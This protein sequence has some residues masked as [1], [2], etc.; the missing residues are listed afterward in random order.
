MSLSYRQIIA[1]TSIA[2]FAFA[3]HNDALAQLNAAPQT[4]GPTTGGSPIRLRQPTQDPQSAAS[5]S[6][7]P[8]R[9]AKLGEFETFV[10]LP[11]LGAELVNEYIA[12]TT[13]TSPVVPPDYV[14]QTGDEVLITLWG[15]VDAD[16][17]LIVDRTGRITLPRVG[18]VQVAG[19]RY[20]E[21]PDAISK[22]VSHV[23]KGYQISISMGRLRAV[24]VYISGFAERPGSYMAAGLSTVTS[25]LLRAGGPSAAG[26][27]RNI[28]LKRNGKNVTTIDLYDLLLRGEKSSDATLQPGD[29]I[30]IPPIG[31]QA[32]V[33]GSVNR[34]AVFELK[35]GEKLSDLLGWAGDFSPV[36]D[37][38]RVLLERLDERNGVRVREVNLSEMSGTS[39]A[40]GDIIRALSAVNANL[41][42]TA[43][44]RRIRVEGEVARPGDYLLPPNS[45][46][47]DAIRAAG[48]LT[49]SAYPYGAEFSRESV[50]LTQQAN[51]ERALRDLET[52]LARASSA[53]RITTAEEASATSAQTLTSKRLV[54][55]LREVKPTGRIILQTTPESKDLPA[56]VVEDGDRINIPAKPNT[57]GVFGSVFNA[58]NYLHENGKVMGNYLQLAGGP[59]KGADT[60]NAFIIRANG[61][62]VSSAQTRQ[63]WFS[64]NALET[65]GV[66][67]GDTVFVP[68][69][70]NKSTFVQAAKD[71]TQILYQ[72][73]LG[74]AGLVTITR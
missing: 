72:F 12:G 36:A 38:R 28:Q 41:S 50:R 15:S 35:P 54:D 69:E 37:R 13:D 57:V 16:L 18:P 68:E 26:S 51:Y 8:P 43:Q 44:N 52:D 22:R 74:I 17:A 10:Q 34:A 46:L 14:V 7:S 20:A 40:N 39:V 49:V 29:I 33:T 65:T 61:T 42:T 23:F 53:Q 73:G 48:G 32:A 6:T 21:L 63:G 64:T 30:H 66:E 24:R 25:V 3:G 60:A 27:F 5:V 4:E 31:I 9:A 70:V 19:L 56:L 1:A 58:G 2:C 71:W 11:R 67:P 45:S 62:A 59:T 55:R 47:Q